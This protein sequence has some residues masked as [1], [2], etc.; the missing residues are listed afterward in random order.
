MNEKELKIFIGNK[1]REYRKQ[2]K[3]T[4]KE[5]GDRAG[6]KHNTIATYEKGHSSPD[7]NVIFLLAQALDRPVDD[8]FPNHREEKYLN[9]LPELTNANLDFEELLFL[10]EIIEK[11]L[12]LEGEE[13]ARFLESIKFTVEYYKKMNGN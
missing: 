12:S 9:Q 6:V 11:T 5:L 4:Q 8:F 10:N 3:M 2:M 1:I 13:R 7:Q